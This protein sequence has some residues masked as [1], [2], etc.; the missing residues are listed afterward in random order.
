MSQL[1]QSLDL[2]EE[3]VKLMLA[4][5][6]HLGS[7][8]CESQMKPYVWRRRTEDGTHIIDLRKTWE[9][10]VLAARAIVTVPNPD[11]VCVV[12]LSK[13]GS[14]P[15]AQRAILRYSKLTGSH[16][17]AGKFTP[18]SFTN[19][20]QKEYYEPRL[21]VVADP[22]K[23]HQPVTEASYTNTPV[24]ALSNTDTPLR[25]VDI[26]IPCNNKGKYSIALVFWL[27]TREVL[28]LRGE[29]P[30]D[31]PWDTLVDVFI[32]P[33]QDEL[34]KQMDEMMKQQNQA[35]V[36][37]QQQKYQEFVE[38]SGLVAEPSKEW[39]DDTL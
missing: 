27:L 24:I 9:K 12:A 39:A 21:L 29:I 23:D 1:P 2:S 17:I 30:R 26:V 20:R 5:H 8:N 25:H 33:E 32:Q 36:Q 34:E 11:D 3:D 31:Q 16:S 7:R 10:I 22:V 28:R 38:S 37:A 4:C 14:T 18:G 13:Q 15:Y 6:V 19:Y 35:L